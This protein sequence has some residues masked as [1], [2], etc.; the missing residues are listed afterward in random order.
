[1]AAGRDES[2]K[3]IMNSLHEKQ[4]RKITEDDEKRRAKKIREYFFRFSY[5]VIK[6]RAISNGTNAS[7]GQPRRKKKRERERTNKPRRF[8]F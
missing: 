7:G 1:M 4:E 8:I 2:E 6:M 3:E 5:F